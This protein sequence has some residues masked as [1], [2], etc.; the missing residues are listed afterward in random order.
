GG[1]YD[2]VGT[3][4]KSEYW[5]FHV[6]MVLYLFFIAILLLNVLI[7]LINVA[8]TKGDDGWRLS[9]VGNRL[10]YIEDAENMSYNITGGLQGQRE[11]RI[12]SGDELKPIFT[13]Q[14]II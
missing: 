1:R 12:K 4:F 8:F 2:P 14:C 7:A 6:M 5:A 13:R 10:R 3:E 11:L 9:W